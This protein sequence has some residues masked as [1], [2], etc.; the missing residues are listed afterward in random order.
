MRVGILEILIADVNCGPLRR[1]Y[2]RHVNRHYASIMPQAVAVWSRRRGHQTF[3]AT[4]WGQ[5]DPKSLLPDDLDVVFLSAHTSAS[6]LAYALARLFRREGTLTV[7]GGPHAKGFPEDALRFFDVVV[8][9]CDRMLVEEILVDRPRGVVVSS[10]RPLSEVPTVEERLPELEKA[11][12]RHGPTTGPVFV[13]ILT[14]LG[15]PYACDFCTDWDRPYRLTP[16]DQLETDL[17]FVSERF[18]KARI[19]FH[20]PNFAVKFDSVL[21][22]LERI[23]PGARNRYVIQSSLSVLREN[24][25]RRLRDTNCSYLAPGLESWSEY[26]NK[27]NVARGRSAR[28][29]LDEVVAHFER[30]QEYVPGLQANFIFGVDSDAGSEP[31]ELTKEFMDRL[32]RVWSNLNVPTPFG[33]TPLYDRYFAEGRILRA[34]P[35]AFYYTPYLATTL[36]SYTAGEYYGHLIELFQHMTSAETVARR[37]RALSG[38]YHLFHALRL[39]NARRCLR[40]FRA[41]QRLLRA[42]RAFRAFHEGV[43]DKLPIFYQERLRS[44]LGRYATLLSAAECRPV[45][46]PG[47]ASRASMPDR[48]Q[49]RSARR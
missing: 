1:L 24:R 37:M 38:I 41:L 19:P 35:F 15:C 30:I 5:A 33:G 27:A 39:L 3:Y 20:D 42:D 4:Y 49:R 16:V 17:R 11:H 40:E 48:S 32:P 43:S 36:R 14:S 23:P 25:L 7:L 10:P 18:P 8:A 28:Q 12:F 29:K 34:M 44:L 21:E 13:S 9:E 31:V 22:V 2:C 46:V 47:R 26:S 45:L 6:A